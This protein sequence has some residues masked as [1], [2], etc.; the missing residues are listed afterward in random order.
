MK[1]IKNNDEVMKIYEN[2]MTCDETNKRQWQNN[3]QLCI[4]IYENHDEIWWKSVQN[5]HQ[6]MKMMKTVMNCDKKVF[7]IIFRMYMYWTKLSHD[8]IKTRK[9]KII[10]R[11]RCSSKN[12]LT[13]PFLKENQNHKDD[14]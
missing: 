2:M 9:T 14:N 4:Y 11:N 12:L 3:E 10:W 6:I 13:A 7:F 8:E 1:T 5:I